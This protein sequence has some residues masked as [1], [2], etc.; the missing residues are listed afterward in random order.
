M[1][2]DGIARR[3]AAKT[4]TKRIGR[5]GAVATWPRLTLFC[6]SAHNVPIQCRRQP[7]RGREGCGADEKYDPEDRLHER[8]EQ[9]DCLCETLKRGIGHVPISFVLT[10]R[11]DIPF[12]FSCEVSTIMLYSI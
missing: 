5:K 6:A 9:E 4:I 1:R 11:R 12:S 2:G 10:G 8:D 7:H 3:A